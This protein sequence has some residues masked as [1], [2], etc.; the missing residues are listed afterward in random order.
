TVSLNRPNEEEIS[1]YSFLE[2]APVVLNVDFIETKLWYKESSA[3]GLKQFNA[4]LLKNMSRNNHYVSDESIAIILCLYCFHPNKAEK[5]IESMNQILLSC[6]TEA[7]Y[8]Q[9][10]IIPA[11]LSFDYSVKVEPFYIGKLN[12]DRLKTACSRADS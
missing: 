12:N 4:N 9:F 2:V 6:S 7:N 11:K 1:S 10:F 8:Q 3:F 5:P